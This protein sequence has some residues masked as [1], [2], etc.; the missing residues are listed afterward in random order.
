VGLGHQKAIVADPGDSASA[1]SAAMNRHKLADAIAAPDYC[2][3]GL[4][5]ELQ[6]LRRQANRDKRIK[7][8]LVTDAGTAIYYALAIDTY[9]VTEGHFVTDH[10]ERADV[11]VVADPGLGTNYSSRMNLH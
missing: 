8:R 3:A 6:I 9:P 10:G 5:G 7:M 2:F 1:G 4:A 11:A